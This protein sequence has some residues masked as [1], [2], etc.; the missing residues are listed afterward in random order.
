MPACKQPGG[1]TVGLVWD[2]L[3]QSGPG[4]KDKKD[5]SINEATVLKR[6]RRTGS[7]EE[8]ERLPVIQK[9]EQGHTLERHTHI[10]RS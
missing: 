5:L 7:K 3:K 9:L 4:A 10:H 6:C 2:W 1:G 8:S